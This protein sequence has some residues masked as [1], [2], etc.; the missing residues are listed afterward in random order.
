[1][2]EP[3]QPDTSRLR[4]IVIL[5]VVFCMFVALFS[6]LWFLQVINAPTAQATAQDQGVKIIYTQA[7]RGDILDAEGQVLAGNRISEVIEVTD[8][9]EAL[10][11]TSLQTRLG[12]LV[13]MTVKQVHAA[14]N[15]TNVSPSYAP[16]TIVTDASASEILYVQEHQSLFPGVTATTQTL[17]DYTPMG[18]AAANILGYTGLI[19]ASEYSQ[20]KPDGYQLGDEIGQSGVEAEYDSVLEG[21]PGV[22]KVQ[23][24]SQGNPLGVLSETAPIPGQN[25]E[26]TINGQVQETAVSAIEQGLDAARKTIDSTEGTGTQPFPAPAGSAVVENPN[27]GD[28]EALATVPD[29]NNNDFIGGI[30]QAQYNGYNDDPDKPLLDRAIQGEYAPGSTFKLVTATAGLEEGLITPTSTYDDTGVIHLGG[31]TFTD[32]EGESFGP[33][34]VTQ[35]IGV[36]SDNFF[37]YIGEEQWNQRGQL[38]DN[39]EQN[40]AAGY[41]F[42]NPTGI[43]LPGE[44][45]GLIPTQAIQNKE[46]AQ[47]PKAYPYPAWTT[48]ESMQT[49]IGQDQVEVTPLQ[50]AN[51]YSGFANGRTLYTPQLVANAQ[52]AA[53]KVTKTY[54]PIK[55][56]N[57]PTLSTADRAAMLQGYVDVVND[58]YIANQAGGTGYSI[59][60]D[61]VNGKPDPLGNMDIAG[62]TGTAQVTNQPSTSVF[63]SFAPASNPQYEVTCFMEQAGYGAS[64]AGPVVRQIYDQIY[65]LPLEQVTVDGEATND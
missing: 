16:A 59:F 65:N 15:N 14:I 49:A 53:G 48:G 41:G 26:L 44:S 62:K 57:T 17:R 21:T 39:A 18:V 3:T 64:V 24:D 25:I 60:H 12:A 22:E 29:Y 7:P 58:Q 1:V 50:L 46:H 31:Q 54:P 32:D 43:K 23:V 55:K 35:A 8:R 13:G 40:V 51:A 10:Y 45:S 5:V 42:G 38:G 63:T 19:T 11:D 30:S 37:N 28:I 2:A 52:T 61:T 56:G 33:I 47:D 34:N 27:N 9:N 36:S 4:L 20:L 6:R